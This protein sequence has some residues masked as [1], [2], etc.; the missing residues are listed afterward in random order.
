MFPKNCQ[1]KNMKTRSQ[2]KYKIT[3][4]RTKRYFDSPIQYMRRQLN[5]YNKEKKKSIQLLLYAP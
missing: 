1:K 4:A 3:H 5:K 2:E